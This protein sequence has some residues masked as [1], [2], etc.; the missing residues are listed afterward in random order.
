MAEA[1]SGKRPRTGAS[2]GDWNELQSQAA[3]MKA[4]HLKTLLQDKA[5]NDSM[6]V[7]SGGI[8]M[9][10]SREKVD[11]ETMQKLFAVAEKAG[12]NEMKK[13]MFSGVKINETEERPVGHIALRAPRDAVFE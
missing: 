7:R 13:K 11:G 8:V 9:D 2:S 1:A 12:V 4:V 6:F 10:Y 3:K 5:R